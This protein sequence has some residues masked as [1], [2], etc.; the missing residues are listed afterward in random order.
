MTFG[1]SSPYPVIQSFFPNAVTLGHYILQ[2][3]P[4]LA[5]RLAH[6]PNETRLR[7]LLDTAVVADIPL[8]PTTDQYGIRSDNAFTIAYVECSQTYTACVSQEQVNIFS[9]D[10][11]L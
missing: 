3:F 4:D 11:S 2:R 6:V 7:I 8:T 5:Q 1:G 9:N 10:A